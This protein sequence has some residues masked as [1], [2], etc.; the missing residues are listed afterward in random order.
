[1]GINNKE[2]DFTLWLEFEEFHPDQAWDEKNEFFNMLVKFNDRSYALNVWSYGFMKIQLAKSAAEKDGF[3]A[4][5]DLLVDACIRINMEIIV[6][7]LIQEGALKDE[8]VT[9]D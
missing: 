8:W 6:G 1:M 2:S 4:A 5:P 9:G 3:I 7:K